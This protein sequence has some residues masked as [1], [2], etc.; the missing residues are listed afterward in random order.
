MTSFRLFPLFVAVLLQSCFLGATP[1]TS[2]VTQDIYF[3]L[4]KS[5]SIMK[6]EAAENCQKHYSKS[7]WAVISDWA[8]QL[9]ELIKEKHNGYTHDG[10]NGL[11]VS[12][13]TIN[14]VA[15]ILTSFDSSDVSVKEA[16]LYLQQN[17]TVSGGTDPSEAFNAIHKLQNNDEATKTRKQVVVYFTDGGSQ[18]TRYVMKPHGD[19]DYVDCSRCD[20]DGENKRPSEFY[21]VKLD[22]NDKCVRVSLRKH[23]RSEKTIDSALN[24]RRKPTTIY[25]VGLGTSANF[26]ELVSISGNENLVFNAENVT[27]LKAIADLITKAVTDENGT[28]DRED[29]FTVPPSTSTT[30]RP[31]ASEKTST[32][33]SKSKEEKEGKESSSKWWAWA[34]GLIVAAA[35]V[36]EIKR[37]ST[38]LSFN[39]NAY[40]AAHGF[41]AGTR[42]RYHDKLPSD[43]DAH[44]LPDYEDEHSDGSQEG[45]FL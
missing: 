23:D 17:V 14:N 34:L 43:I 16:L 10:C 7:C 41:G 9:I 25:S 15:E 2:C 30:A 3:V 6:E 22:K 35:V 40:A 24:I 29:K 44:A 31:T 21:C 1:A 8:E 13:L 12:I 39:R 19:Y 11:R 36:Y 26:Q 32:P 20:W 28:S 18:R 37:R 33:T 45:D 27:N 42:G 5:K 38:N 4:D